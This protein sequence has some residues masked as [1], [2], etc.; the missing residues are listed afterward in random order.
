MWLYAVSGLHYCGVIMAMLSAHLIGSMS[1]IMA[2][3][4]WRNGVMAAAMA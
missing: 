1:R 4:Q 2:Y 3:H